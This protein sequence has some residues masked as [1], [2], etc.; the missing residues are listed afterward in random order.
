M[1]ELKTLNHCCPVK[2]KIHQQDLDVAGF[3]GLFFITRP[4]QASMYQKEAV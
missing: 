2:I 3:D 1:E 4:V